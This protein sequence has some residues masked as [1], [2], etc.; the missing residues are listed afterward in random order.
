M[1]YKVGLIL[2]NRLGEFT[3]VISEKNGIFGIT[4]WVRRQEDAKKATVA[5]NF[6]N[7]YGL[8]YANAKIADKGSSK[9]AP[10]EKPKEEVVEKKDEIDLVKAKG[11]DLKAYAEKNEIDISGLT[12][13]KDI[14]AKILES[15]K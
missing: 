11:D 7:K 1:N 13:V 6:V 4:G 12:S 15:V 9:V 8:Q 5:R 2:T 3:K 10:S 14:R